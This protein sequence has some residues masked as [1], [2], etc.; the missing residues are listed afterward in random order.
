M[1]FC[2][3]RSI[4]GVPLFTGTKFQPKET[5][6]DGK[7]VT[8]FGNFKTVSTSRLSPLLFLFIKNLICI[9]KSPKLLFHSPAMENKLFKIQYLKCI[10]DKKYHGVCILC[11]LLG[12]KFLP[13]N[14]LRKQKEETTAGF[15]QLINV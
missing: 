12:P 14:P 11:T 8:V 4:L 13:L 3:D 15:T 7:R 1:G 10:F 6:F 5:A 2:M 9:V